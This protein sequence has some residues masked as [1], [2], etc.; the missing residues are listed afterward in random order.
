MP[1]D[2]S[3]VLDQ[4]KSVGAKN[5]DKM[6]ET[7]RTLI[8]KYNVGPDKT[9]VSITTFA[10][11][12]EIRVSLKDEKYQSQEGLNKLIDEMIKKDKLM[13][14]TRTDIALET[15]GKDVFNTNNGDR[16]D[17]PNVMILFTDGGTNVNS[18]PYSEVLP[19]L[20]V[21]VLLVYS[22]SHQEEKPCT[23]VFDGKNKIVSSEF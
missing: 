17:A 7:V 5:Y 16:P 4:T 10:G 23:G 12:A 11:Q 15:V 14:V 3:L 18:K 9:R 22:P 21:R 6:L 2:L 1:L 20:V 19:P 13:K 8:S